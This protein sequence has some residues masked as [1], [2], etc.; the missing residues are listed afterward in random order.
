[1]KLLMACLLLCL[2]VLLNANVLKIESTPDSI[3]NGKQ[4]EQMLAQHDSCVLLLG[5][6]VYRVNLNIKGNVSIY[7]GFEGDS[8]LWRYTP[9]QND[10]RLTVLDGGYTYKDAVAMVGEERALSH[11]KQS[12]IA[13]TEVSN[14]RQFVLDGCT[15]THGS[16]ELY[17]NKVNWGG[18]VFIDSEITVPCLI[19]N[20]I[21]KENYA[22][23]GGGV[24]GGTIQN[25]II[26]S[27]IAVSAGG[28]LFCNIKNSVIQNNRSYRMGGGTGMSNV[29]ECIIKNNE[30]G[31]GGGCGE[32]TVSSSVILL[33]KGVRGGGVYQSKVDFSI[34]SSNKGL[35][36]SFDGTEAF[37][38]KLSYCKILNLMEN[39]DKSNFFY[40]VKLDECT[41]YIKDSSFLFSGEIKSIKRTNKKVPDLE[42]P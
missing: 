42:I 23:A 14:I 24:C 7:G 21:V 15:V 29:E 17:K 13:L 4:L 37:G 20:C 25:S 26:D 40:D 31:D 28:V 12:V 19:R 2:G 41:L 36:D 30:S 38:G 5:E 39:D 10:S 34:F 1:M 35:N 9:S 18:G 11:G 27:N 3:Y 33:N 16:G 22:Y 32:S 6:G 8:A